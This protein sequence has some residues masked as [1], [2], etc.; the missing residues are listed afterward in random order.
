ME[1]TACFAKTLAQL[2]GDIDDMRVRA[3]AWAIGDVAAIANL[4]YAERSQAC[5]SAFLTSPVANS[6]P[7]LKTIVERA[8]ANWLASAERAL[9]DN[10]TTFSVLG[11]KEILDPTGLVAALRARGYSVEPPK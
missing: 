5:D 9:A 10:A 7:E 3:N 6:Q 11:M 4:D 2:E 8:R 1:D